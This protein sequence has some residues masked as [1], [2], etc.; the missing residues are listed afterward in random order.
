MVWL[1]GDAVLLYVDDPIPRFIVLVTA[2]VTIAAW[3]F[4][5]V[6]GR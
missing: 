5:K 2:V 4:R 3:A 6:G 1:A